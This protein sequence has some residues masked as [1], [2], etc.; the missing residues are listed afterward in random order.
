MYRGNTKS[1]SKGTIAIVLGEE[2]Y[3]NPKRLVPDLVLHVGEQKVWLE[4]D[5][6]HHLSRLTGEE[7]DGSAR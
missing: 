7:S 6:V 4:N 1:F 3:Q 2:F 5:K